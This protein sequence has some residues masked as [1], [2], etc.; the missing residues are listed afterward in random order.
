MR[1]RCLCDHFKW[2]KLL[3]VGVKLHDELGI[4]YFSKKEKKKKIRRP[5]ARGMPIPPLLNKGCFVIFH[6]FVPKLKL[7]A[8]K[9]SKILQTPYSTPRN[10]LLAQV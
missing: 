5:I 7:T 2:H 6:P 8:Q 3:K 10:S 4:C 1:K 9:A